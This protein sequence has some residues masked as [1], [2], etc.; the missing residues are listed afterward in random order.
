[1]SPSWPGCAVAEGGGAAPG[2]AA[3]LEPARLPLM[4]PSPPLPAGLAAAE[5]SAGRLGGA[6]ALP[7]SLGL[8]PPAAKNFFFSASSRRSSAPPCPSSPCGPRPPP[9]A[10]ATTAPRRDHSKCCCR[11][12]S[13]CTCDG[14]AARAATAAGWLRMRK[15]GL[16][17]PLLG[18]R[19]RGH[20]PAAARGP[21]HARPAAVAMAPAPSFVI[22]L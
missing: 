16:P 15:A 7:S 6:A 5:G 9:A 4:L 21:P 13:V 19:A 20:G 2:A 11:R 1:M 12:G 22:L 10:A 17:G 3:G 8:P 18:A 14:A